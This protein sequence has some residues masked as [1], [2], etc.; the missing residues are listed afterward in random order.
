[1][2]RVSGG[3]DPAVGLQRDR[4][5]GHVAGHDSLDAEWRQRDEREQDA[6]CDGSGHRSPES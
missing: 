4:V 5:E 3:D 1:V 6:S 2:A